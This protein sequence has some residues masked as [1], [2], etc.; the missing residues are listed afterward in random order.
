MNDS[1]INTFHT[2]CT[3]IYCCEDS[4]V[5]SSNSHVK[6]VSHTEDMNKSFLHCVLTCE[7]SNLFYVYTV[8]HTLSCHHVTASCCRFYQLHYHLQRNIYLYNIHKCKLHETCCKHGAYFTHKFHR[9]TIYYVHLFAVCQTINKIHYYYYMDMS[10][11]K[12]KSQEKHL[13]VTLE[14]E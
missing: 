3:C 7:N 14:T 2:E 10:S 4:Y 5:S 11:Y 6:N 9:H 8:C 12:T 13:F 1:L